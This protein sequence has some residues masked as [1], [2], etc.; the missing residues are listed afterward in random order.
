MAKWMNTEMKDSQ[1]VRRTARQPDRWIFCFVLISFQGYCSGKEFDWTPW[2]WRGV[3]MQ[4]DSKESCLCWRRLAHKLV[5]TLAEEREKGVQCRSSNHFGCTLVP[6]RLF[7]SWRKPPLVW[8]T[9]GKCPFSLSPHT[10]QSLSYWEGTHV[11][12]VSQWD[13]RKWQALNQ[14]LVTNISH[15]TWAWFFWSHIGRLNAEPWNS[16]DVWLST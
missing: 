2:D 12:H 4:G 16:L 11:T 8:W 15:R 14:L 9:M 10:F 7:P 5:G 3:R 13:G 6:C 1:S